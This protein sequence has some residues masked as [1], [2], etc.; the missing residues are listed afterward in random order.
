MSLI[1]QHIGLHFLVLAIVTSLLS[2]F[3]SRTR[4]N[5]STRFLIP[6]YGLFKAMKTSKLPGF[7]AVLILQ[8]YWLPINWVHF[9]GIAML[10]LWIYRWGSFYKRSSRF[11]KLT[12]GL[13]ICLSFYSLLHPVYQGITGLFLNGLFEVD[14]LCLF[15]GIY[16]FSQLKKENFIEK[17]YAS[18]EFNF[19]KYALQQF[20]KNLP[21]RISLYI[22]G[23]LVMVGFYADFL[24]NST[25]IFIEQDGKLHSPVYE[26]L[27]HPTPS[28]T[29]DG[30]KV[31]YGQVKWRSL[32][33][34]KS[35]F[36][37]IPYSPGDNDKYNRNFAS[38]GGKQR[39]K[40]EEGK[41]IKINSRFKH[42]LGTD[43]IGR[44]VAA[45]L[46][47]ATRISLTVGL[48][49]MGIAAI[50]GIILGALA[51][52]FGNEKL[53]AP[54][55]KYLMIILGLIMGYFYA[56]ITLE[57]AAENAR[58]EGSSVL[59]VYF[60]KTLLICGLPLLFAYLSRFF[61]AVKF[62]A[63]PIR[64]PL[65][66]IVMR[67][68]EVLNSIP[69]LLLIITIAATF[70]EKSLVLIMIVIGLTSWT[71]IARFTRAEFLRIREL[72]YMEAT[73]ALGYSNRRAIFKHATPNA[74]APVFVSIAFGIASAILIESSLSFLG[75]GVPE[76]TVTWGS[77]LNEYRQNDEAWWLI[78]F[79]GL[80]IFVTITIYNLIGEGLR[81]ALDPKLKK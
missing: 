46:I 1:V 14:I 24:A 78:V 5:A 59:F 19:S 49:S 13:G 28:L 43:Q 75:I 23:G 40:T 66:S 64:I 69:R 20:H 44:D 48:I 31:P 12:L 8:C 74:L 80:A 81:D 56:F 25:P 29:I 35:T 21:A 11:D 36:A 38:P 61:M 26:Q 58:N 53:I 42:H 52:F 45:G 18:N 15:V 2:Y 33:G 37:L 65:D 73:R 30:Q 16:L 50:I 47:H 54:R 41:F 68:I 39:D 32:E 70:E 51:G 79:P 6:F 22:L 3:F 76:E 10:F 17:K 4:T 62:L 9:I 27:I 34:V 60:I 67:A 7:I 72:N 57:F 77:L 71:G 55:I 63:K